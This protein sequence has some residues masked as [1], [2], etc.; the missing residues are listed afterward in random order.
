MGPPFLLLTVIWLRVQSW[1]SVGIETPPT[2]SFPL[3]GTTGFSQPAVFDSALWLDQFLGFLHVPRPGLISASADGDGIS[4]N[5]HMPLTTELLSP[6]SSPDHHGSPLL[7]FQR[8][9]PPPPPVEPSRT[10]PLDLHDR[11]F[12]T[13]NAE[14]GPD[15]TF[16]VDTGFDHI[17]DWHAWSRSGSGSPFLEW[18]DHESGVQRRVILLRAA[19]ITTTTPPY[20]IAA[21][22]RLFYV[23]LPLLSDVA[24]LLEGIGPELTESVAQMD[25]AK[26]HP[27]EEGFISELLENAA[28]HELEGSDSTSAAAAAPANATSDAAV[29]T[30]PDRS[31]LKFSVLVAFLRLSVANLSSRVRDLVQA[32]A[33]HGAQIQQKDDEIAAKEQLLKQKDDKISGQEN[34]IEWKDERILAMEN[35][36]ADTEKSSKTMKAA[37]R[38]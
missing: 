14:V 4:L 18:L 1:W 10:I 2:I 33:A 27:I 34:L 30:D 23:A 25:S 6:V 28:R 31:I 38:N 5:I 36:L 11:A 8:L 21:L 13:G 17:H 16:F 35:E 9:P 26:S 24:L 22:L 29:N 37:P 3:D 15:A 32:S 20:G 7:E 19:G 12:V